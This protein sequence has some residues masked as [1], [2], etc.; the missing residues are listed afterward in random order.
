[1][2]YGLSE[3]MRAISVSFSGGSPPE[4]EDANSARFSAW[5]AGVAERGMTM[6]APVM[7]SQER[8]VCSRG[9]I[10]REAVML[11]ARYACPLPP[12]QP[13]PED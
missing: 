11:C 1:L 10:K 8:I 6:S 3:P 2:A 9:S 12:Q 7:S 4:A 13:F 5:C